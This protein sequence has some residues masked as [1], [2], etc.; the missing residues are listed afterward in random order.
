ML[1]TTTP[2]LQLISDATYC[3]NSLQNTYI[4]SWYQIVIFK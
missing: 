2:L 3:E 4:C 1:Q